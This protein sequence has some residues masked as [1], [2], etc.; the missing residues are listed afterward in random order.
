MLYLLAAV[1]AIAVAVLLW[2][3]FISRP[4]DVQSR[5]PAPIAPDDDPDFLRRLNERKKRPDEGDKQPPA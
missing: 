3:A 4:A 2:R 1:G 5:R